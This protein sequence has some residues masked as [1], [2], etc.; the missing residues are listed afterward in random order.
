MGRPLGALLA[1]AADRLGY[2]TTAQAVTAGVS[3]RML[4]HYARL[5][6]VERMRKGV[7]RLVAHPRHRL[8]AILVTCLWAGSEAVASHES[9]LV[10][11]GVLDDADGPA[12][13]TV[14][15]GGFRGR[16]TDAV[17][18]HATV[19]AHDTDEVEG[20]PVTGVERMTKDLARTRD[21]VVM[22]PLIEAMLE[23]GVVDDAQLR[24]LSSAC[25]AVSM[26]ARRTIF[27]LNRERSEQQAT[28]TAT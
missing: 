3:R 10:V 8:E 25:P 26:A 21:P 7:Y 28:F 1:L 14:P 6:Y 22:R 20:I 15:P 12:H 5:G 2:F 18:H 13:V 17:V 9:A 4:S 11:H 27:R 23:R 19:A 24:A 16:R